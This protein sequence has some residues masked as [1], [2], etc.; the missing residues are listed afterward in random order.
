MSHKIIEK[1]IEWDDFIA[2]LFTAT[3]LQ[4]GDY[5]FDIGDIFEDSELLNQ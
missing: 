5:Y 3:A 1:D 4:Y 2:F